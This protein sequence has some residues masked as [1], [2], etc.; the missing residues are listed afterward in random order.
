MLKQ[1]Y[2]SNAGHPNIE[3]PKLTTKPQKGKKA[4][5]IP[6]GAKLGA[7]DPRSATKRQVAVAVPRRARQDHGYR[8]ID[9]VRSKKRASVISDAMEEMKMRNDAYR[10]PNVRAY[11]TD[12]EKARMQEKFQF[13]GGKGLPEEMTHPE[14]PLPSALRAEKKEQERVA[15]EWRKRRGEPEPAPGAPPPRPDV[16]RELVETIAAEIDDRQT[17]LDHMHKLGQ[18]NDNTRR[19]EAEIAAR[20]HELTKATAAIA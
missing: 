16:R 8:P 17:F 20:K 7:A 5:F 15:K 11:S 2:G 6:G 3:Y 13:G 10:P 4:A 12:A 1:L 18:H 19:V 9:F 14:G